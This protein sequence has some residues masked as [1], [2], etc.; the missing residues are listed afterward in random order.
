[1]PTIT[2]WQNAWHMLGTEN[3][4]LP[5][6]LY[7]E[8]IAK[9]DEPH[10]CYH[11][12]QHLAECLDKFT[13]LRHLAINPAEI[14]LALWFHDAVY[15]PTRH[16]NELLSAEWA[17]SSVISAG[18][19]LAIASRVYQLIMATQHHAKPENTDTQVLIDIDLA[20]LGANPERYHEYEQ[21]IRQEYAFVPE[22]IFKAKRS[23]ILQ[24]F[25]ALPTIFNTPLF[26]E[27]YEQQART[28]INQAVEQLCPT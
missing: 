27:R 21:Q 1:M 20:I 15:E 28:N 2:Q 6:Q 9:Y 17:K 11:T 10:R 7:D 12:Q 14:E 26:I 23:E 19:D 24:R 25:L 3:A 22:P 16:D 4:K 18:L 5:I 8:V 13:E